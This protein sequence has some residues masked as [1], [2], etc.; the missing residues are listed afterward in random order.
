MIWWFIQPLARAGYWLLTIQE[1]IIKF[2]DKS[3]EKTLARSYARLTKPPASTSSSGRLIYHAVWL[4]R[5]LVINKRSNRVYVLVIDNQKRMLLVKNWLGN[6]RWRLPGGGVG[7]GEDFKVAA[8]RELREELQLKIR[9]GQLTEI[10]S[11]ATSR[12]YRRIVFCLSV[13]P[14]PTNQSQPG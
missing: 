6:G 3:G 4:Y 13:A 5:L 2:N 14:I 1:V 11:Q 12:R 8:A 7:E 9:P 10:Y